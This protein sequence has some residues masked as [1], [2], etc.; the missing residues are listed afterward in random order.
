MPSFLF[1][2]QTIPDNIYKRMTM[3]ET[4]KCLNLMI[5]SVNK[6]VAVAQ[7]Y[8]NQEQRR[9]TK[10]VMPSWRSCLPWCST[11]APRI[12]FAKS[13]HHHCGRIVA[14]NDESPCKIKLKET[15][16]AHTRVFNT[17][18]NNNVS[19]NFIIIVT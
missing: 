2:D 18:L 13:P 16:M 8:E 6:I 4:C 9:S 12:F 17:S 19:I 15:C 14:A 11:I 3:Y 5:A 1:L 7:I 10:R